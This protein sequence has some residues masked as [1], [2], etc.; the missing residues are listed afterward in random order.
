MTVTLSRRGR[1]RRTEDEP[2]AGPQEQGRQ[3]MRHQRSNDRLGTDSEAQDSPPDY[4]EED[5]ER[6]D[7]EAE[8]QPEGVEKRQTNHNGA[9]GQADD[10]TTGAALRRQCRNNPLL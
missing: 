10:R 2:R 8:R 4:G 9:S 1:S 6:D 5:D 7:P 3:Q